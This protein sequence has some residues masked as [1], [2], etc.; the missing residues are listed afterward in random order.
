MSLLGERYLCTVVLEDKNQVNLFSCLFIYPIFTSNQYPT[1]RDDSRISAIMEDFA[2]NFHNG[3]LSPIVCEW[4]T[5]DGQGL[6]ADHDKVMA[7]VDWPLLLS[8]KE[9]NVAARFLQELQQSSRNSNAPIY[10]SSLG[11][12]CLTVWTHADLAVAKY[13][14]FTTPKHEG[15]SLH[16]R[17]C[18]RD[19]S[20]TTR[21]WRLRV[22]W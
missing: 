16:R 17:H 12:R 1:Q 11:I 10:T 7:A 13:Q 21:R 22:G 4:H 3:Q 6:H 14:T 9:N 15:K 19:E 2:R 18:F 8:L 20:N 5:V